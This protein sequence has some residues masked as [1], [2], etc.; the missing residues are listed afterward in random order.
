MFRV[1]LNTKMQY[2][3][4]YS[5][6]KRDYG[7]LFFNNVYNHFINGY[8]GVEDILND[9]LYDDDDDNII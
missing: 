8:I 4:L 9:I 3:N 1:S 5:L 2:Q 6:Q 7:F